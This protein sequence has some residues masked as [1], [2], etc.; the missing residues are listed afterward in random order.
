MHVEQLL[1]LTP[2]GLSAAGR[3]LVPGQKPGHRLC[4]AECQRVLGEPLVLLPPFL[5]KTR[6]GDG[7]SVVQRQKAGQWKGWP[8]AWVSF[9][10]RQ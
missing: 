1:T 5:Q 8:G 3:A 4:H 10:L 6:S 7:S 2:R 9:C